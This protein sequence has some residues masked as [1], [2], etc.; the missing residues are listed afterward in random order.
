MI[1]SSTADSNGIFALKEM[2]KVKIY[3]KKSI[4]NIINERKYLS[5][6][7]NPFIINMNYAFETEEN[8]YIVMDYLSGGDLRYYLCRHN[9]ISE[10]KVKFIVTNILLALKY[11]HSKHIIHRDLKPENLV[12]D[13]KGYLHLTDFGI[14]HEYNEGDEII[15]SSGTPGY[16]A[17]EIV[18]RKPHNFNVDFFGLGVIIYE[19][20]TGKR[21]YNGKTRKELKE[22]MLAQEVKLTV[23]MLPKKWKDTNIIE[24]VNGLL[25]RK[26]NERLG[27]NG[28]EEVMSHE[29][30]YDVDWEEIESMRAKS[31]FHIGDNDN[32]DQEYANREDDEQYSKDKEYY[33][34][35]VNRNQFF[36]GYYFNVLE[37]VRNKLDGKEI[38]NQNDTSTIS[39]SH[40][41]RSVFRKIPKHRNRSKFSNKKEQSVRSISPFMPMMNE[42][43]ERST[44]DPLSM[45]VSPRSSRVII[46]S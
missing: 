22:Q 30:L 33:L 20:I 10:S 1:A 17:P 24:F 6:L 44:I 46:N 18:L 7:N 34:R 25:K 23:E 14:S 9:R 28:I 37:S 27:S 3:I 16:M 21:P 12:F 36:K 5:M 40:T 43:K 19:L 31:P 11:I 15:D 42:E 32:F 39:T 2:S 26:A 4:Q 45:R 29:W 38:T 41:K 13:S 35:I 8:L